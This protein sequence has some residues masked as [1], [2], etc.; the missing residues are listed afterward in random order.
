[1]II[2]YEKATRD[3]IENIYHLCKSLINTYENI[4]SIDY[5]KVLKWA[6]NKIEKCISEYTAIFADG[7]KAGYYHF[8][9]NEHGEYELDDLYVFHEYQNRGI[10][11]EIIKKCCESTDK[12]VTLYTF[13]KN[14]RAVA[15]YKRHGFE[16]VNNISKSR[17]LMK[18]QGRKY[19]KAYD[20][21]Y[22]TAHEK[23]IS[24]SSNISTPIVMDIMSRYNIKKND[25]IL[26]VG[27]GEGRDSKVLLENGF[28]LIATDVSWEAVSYCKNKMPEY[29]SRF[30]VLDCI[31]DRLSEKFDFIF[32]V[33][34]IHMLVLDED[35]NNFYQFIHNHLAEDGIALICTMG[36]GEV[37]MQSDI[38]T[39]FTLQER[40]HESGKIMVAATSCRMV[41][42]PHFVEEITK[43]GLNVI[44][45]GITSSL[46]DFDKLM[47]AIVNM[48][49]ISQKTK[50]K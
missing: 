49:S 45:K 41:T 38:S 35:R 6:H 34:V 22:K 47:Y 43:N 37:E 12:Q 18:N 15:L 1:M 13:I 42:F 30:S 29:S 50:Q 2:T 19:Y 17:Y 33:A 26:E 31:S 48:N 3:D 9:I 40:N 44:E 4:E 46:P 32:G 20:E 25:K 39:A 16:I 21:R 36:D 7:K 8:Y 5:H 23:G 10:G 27:C 24:W 11:S 14:D 28:Q